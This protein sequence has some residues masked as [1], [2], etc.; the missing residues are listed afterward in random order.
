MSHYVTVTTQFRDPKHLADALRERFPNARVEL[1]EK[2]V[3]I[4]GYE[5]REGAACSVVVRR[6]R[7]AETGPYYADLGYRLEADGTYSVH[8]DDMEAADMLKGVAQSYATRVAV[9]KAKA[10]GFTVTQER[11]TEGTIKL[12]LSKWS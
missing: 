11:T 10:S 3:I 1:H 2:P 9:A 5:G 12:T 6:T 4:T 8:A 7:N